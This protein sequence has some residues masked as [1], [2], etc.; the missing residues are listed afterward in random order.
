MTG[1]KIGKNNRKVS[2]ESWIINL[3][4]YMSFKKADIVIDFTGCFLDKY[5]YVKILI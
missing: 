4:I 2:A 1:S 5:L 3:I